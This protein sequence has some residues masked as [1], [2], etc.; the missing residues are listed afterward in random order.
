MIIFFYIFQFDST[1]TLVFSHIIQPHQQ[2]I[3][4][5]ISVKNYFN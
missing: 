2:H 3:I 1:I 4:I 5:T